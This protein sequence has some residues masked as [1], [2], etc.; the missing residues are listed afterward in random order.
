MVS[1]ATYNVR[2]LAGIQKRRNV[3]KFLQNKFYD[4]ILLQETHSTKNI[5]KVWKGQFGGQ[6]V[7]SHGDSN[8]KGCAILIKKGVKIVIHRTKKSSDGRFVILY[9]TVNDIRM[10]ICNLY[11][12]NTD[13]PVFFTTV[14]NEIEILQNEHVIIG[15]DFNTILEVQDKKGGQSNEPGHPKSVEII[16]S[17]A[18]TNA[19][20]DIFRV[21]YPEKCRYTWHRKRPNIIFERLDYF[22]VSA[23]LSSVILDTD[24]D[25]AFLSD[26]SIPHITFRACVPDS[27]PGFWK[28]NVKLLEDEGFVEQVR[29]ILSTNASMYS[30]IRLRCQ[31]WM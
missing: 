1:L 20:L 29:E 30:D 14:F 21:R 18:E 15:G 9:I 6:I 17:S 5:E 7:Y 22:L 8:A 12:P 4:I 31:K 16:K 2:G 19:W 11:A 10:T 25:P 13:S 23:G 26:H 28:F 27:G 3:F 24:I